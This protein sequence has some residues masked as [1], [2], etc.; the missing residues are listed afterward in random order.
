[1]REAPRQI[2]CR[3][4]RNYH[5]EKLKEDLRNSDWLRLLNCIDVNEAWGYMKNILSGVLN[6]HAPIIQRRV[7]GKA[8][9]WLN[10]GVNRLM[11]E[12]DKVLRKFRKAKSEVY[13]VAYKE[14]RNAVNIAVR[15]GKSSFHRKLLSENAGNPNIF[16]R[17]IK[18]IYP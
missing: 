1:M 12:R 14:K 10:K 13:Q 15:K 16:W 4:H 3:N 8:A 2:T 7:K 9:P 5:Q 18:S 17:T 11:N 6:K